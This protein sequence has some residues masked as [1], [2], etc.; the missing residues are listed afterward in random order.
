MR[1]GCLVCWCRTNR[2]V[3]RLDRLRRAATVPTLELLGTIEKGGTSFEEGRFSEEGESKYSAVQH[4]L[5][6][7]LVVF[8]RLSELC[9]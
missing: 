7:R 3:L 5:N 9:I 1:G 4:L 6:E 8:H 2:C